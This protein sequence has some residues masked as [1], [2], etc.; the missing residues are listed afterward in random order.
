MINESPNVSPLSS[1]QHQKQNK[2]MKLVPEL[3]HRAFW[4]S[5][6]LAQWSPRS[7]ISFLPSQSDAHSKWNP[8]LSTPVNKDDFNYIQ[9][10]QY[11]HSLNILEAFSNDLSLN[12]F[13]AYGL[14]IHIFTKYDIYMNI[15]TNALLPA[16]HRTYYSVW[17]T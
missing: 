15:G 11:V 12:L 14:K 16:K 8:F 13:C 10:M 3:W 5:G 2:V 1:F 6:I 9:P 7:F 17:N 4:P